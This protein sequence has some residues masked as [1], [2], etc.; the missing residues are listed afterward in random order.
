M[1]FIG[2]GTY[3]ANVTTMTNS[4]AKAL[5]TRPEISLSVVNLFE[6]NFS[7]FSSYLGR[8]GFAKKGLVRG[9]S[10]DNF[11]V[12]GNTK[13]QWALK[14]YPLRKGTVVTAPTAAPGY[15]QLGQNGSFFELVLNTDFFSPNDVLELGDRR[16][17]L[18]VMDEYPTV[19]GDNEFSYKVKLVTNDPT[20]FVPAALVAVGSE[21]GASHTAFHEMS[22]TGYEKNTFPEWHTNYMTIQ[23]MQFS[24]SGSAHNTVLWIEHNGQ[25]LWMYEQERE[26]MRRWALAREN[27]LLF[28]KATK[29][30]DD[31]VYL[32]DLKGRDIVQGDGLI[33]Q[34][35]GSLKFQYN[36]LTVRV[37]EN[38]MAQMQLMSNG[39][40]VTELF[41]LA[42][43]K[44]VWDFQRLMRDVYKY[45][46]L[47]LLVGSGDD[48]GVN[49]NFTTYSI[50]GVKVT[51]AWHKPF[52]A[53]F[54]PQQRDEYGIN[55]ESYRAIFTSLGNTIGGDP[56]VELIA[57]GNGQQ[58]RT[59][60]KKTITGMVEPGSNPDG[61][62]SN[63]MDAFQVQILSETGICLKNPFGVAELF[64]P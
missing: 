62:A 28:G 14:G 35:D 46:P 10:T 38:I 32:R 64:K 1:R 42:G 39:D 13:F 34:G 33:A 57:L 20:A 22:E 48:K 36:T 31:N 12:I 50:G 2:T 5:L 21:V 51:V 40:N 25:K 41:I 61:F 15:S 43:Q 4:L 11:R 44:F 23:R 8:R 58:D 6:D 53:V 37:L 27:Q 18:Q 30:A 24:I 45:N 60:V 54:R 63:S 52:D 7:A 56:M 55:K 47:P 29:D 3:N 17:L 49:A 59:F 26:M 9:M 19:L 16:T